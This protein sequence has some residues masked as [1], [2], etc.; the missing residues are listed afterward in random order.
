MH[1]PNILGREASVATMRIH[2]IAVGT[3]MPKWVQD[4]YLEYAKRLP[5]E[6]SLVLHEVEPAKRNKTKNVDKLKQEE[7]KKIKLVLPKKSKI[8]AL[9]VQASACST[10]ELSQSLKIWMSDGM[11]VSLL[12]G[13]PDGLDDEILKEASGKISLSKLTF[14]HPIVRVVLAEQIYRAW[15]ILINHP[16]HRA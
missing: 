6:C 9:D 8:I 13:G 7:A 1:Y 14:P 12:I 15:T 3:R 5:K 11:D 4:G 10:E 2:L 16:Y